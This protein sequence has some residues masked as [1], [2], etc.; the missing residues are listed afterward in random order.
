MISTQLANN[1]YERGQ[2]DAEAY[3]DS[4]TSDLVKVLNALGADAIRSL[5]AFALKSDIL[6][7]RIFVE[8]PLPD[9]PL[10]G[11]RAGESIPELFGLSV[12]DDFPTD[13]DLNAYE[14]N[15]HQGFWKQ[16]RDV[17]FEAHGYLF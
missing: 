4:L 8:F 2:V 1:A 13:G 17:A 14:D 12:G 16:V 7:D 10:S 3:L 6:S 5:V 11:E 15:Y 9:S